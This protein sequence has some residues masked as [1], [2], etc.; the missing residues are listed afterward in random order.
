M[1]IEGALMSKSRNIALRSRDDMS[2]TEISIGS[3]CIVS[4]LVCDQILSQFFLEFV[5]LDKSFGRMEFWTALDLHKSKTFK[6]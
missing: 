1:Y 6:R 3:E 4:S 2:V 5:A